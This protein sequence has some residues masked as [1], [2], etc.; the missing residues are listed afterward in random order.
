MVNRAVQ[1][2]WDET[3]KLFTSLWPTAKDM[4]RG[5]TLEWEARLRYRNQNQVR[6][7][8]RNV[9]SK[10]KFPRNPPA[11]DAVMNECHNLNQSARLSQRTPIITATDDN[12]DEIQREADSVR[13]ILKSLP[14]A[15]LERHKKTA[16]EAMVLLKGFSR[17]AADKH[18]VKQQEQ[19]VKEMMGNSTDDPMKWST[20][21]VLCVNAAMVISSLKSESSQPEWGSGGA[22]AAT[23]RHK[24][25]AAGGDILESDIP[26]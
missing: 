14:P 1:S 22:A 26:F 12:W 23:R 10:V 11:L 17:P 24:I 18:A 21:F 15:D 7:A 19:V 13:S 16:C 20:A 2:E 5:Q 25:T 6:G 3:W 8:I 4:T 9:Y